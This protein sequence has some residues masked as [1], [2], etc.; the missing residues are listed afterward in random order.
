M[1][2]QDMGKHR[3]RSKSLNRS[4]GR[5]DHSGGLPHLPSILNT[6]NNGKT[7]HCHI[8][9]Y[10]WVH[11]VLLQKYSHFLYNGSELAQRVWC[12]HFSMVQLAL[13]APYPTA[14]VSNNHSMDPPGSVELLPIHS[15]GTQRT[16]LRRSIK[17]PQRVK[18]DI[19]HLVPT[20]TD[21]P[22]NPFL[23]GPFLTLLMAH[24]STSFCFYSMF[25][26]QMHAADG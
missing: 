20:C 5:T 12:L 2:L 8:Y 18:R 21:F 7:F 4:L 14:M 22:L 11:T 15:K 6:Y 13:V 19:G 16:Q 9:V 23:V 17:I 10:T 3:K 26:V 1:S 25:L 24:S